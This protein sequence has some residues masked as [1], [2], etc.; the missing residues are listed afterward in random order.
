MKDRSDA[1]VQGDESYDL[2]ISLRARITSE[3]LDKFNL[4]QIIKH[5]SYI[6]TQFTT[7]NIDTFWCL[8][9]DQ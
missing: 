7:F 6:F 5:R 9:S 4:Y 2:K 1:S 3:N 8:T